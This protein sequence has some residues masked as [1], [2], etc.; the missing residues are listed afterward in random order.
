M[1]TLKG[2]QNGL[3]L[4]TVLLASESLQAGGVAG[5]QLALIP[6]VALHSPRTTIHGV[7]L[8]LLCG[9]N[10][11]Q[12][13][14]CGLVNLTTEC[15]AGFCLGAIN[16][17]DSFAGFQCGAIDISKNGFSGFQLGAFNYAKGEVKGLQVGVIN[18]A[19]SLQGLQVGAFN[20][21]DRLR[22]FQIGAANIATH[23][24]WFVGLPGSLSAAFP[25]INWSF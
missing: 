11:Q 12:G 2:I 13:V 23:N 17:A 20:Y 10:Q 21:S 9:Q 24:P 6:D 8:N 14:T 18:I 7:S 4:I 5:F 15:S 25:V 19:D 3:C 1:K 22:G 16:V